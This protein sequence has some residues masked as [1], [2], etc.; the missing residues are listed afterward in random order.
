MGT[1]P[2]LARPSLAHRPPFVSLSLFASYHHH[3]H[4][5]HPNLGHEEEEE[6]QLGGGLPLPP[7]AMA[8]RMALRLNDVA[9]CTSLPLATR[10]SH[11]CAGSVRVL[12][13]ASTPSTVST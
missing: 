9:L 5:P 13:V 8:S 1:P 11:R 3:H 10:H 7:R 12:A 6:E 2:H 4:H